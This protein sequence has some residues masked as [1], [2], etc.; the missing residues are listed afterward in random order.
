M[1]GKGK[2]GAKA[3]YLPPAQSR[4]S[5]GDGDGGPTITEKIKARKAAGGAEEW[6]AFKARVAK[7][8]Q[9]QLAVENHD[10]LMAA[11]HR[12][13]LD[14]ERDARLRREEQP[15]VEKKRKGRDESDSDDSSSS[16]SRKRHR[17]HKHKHKHRDKDKKKH[18]RRSHDKDK[19]KHR[20]KHKRRHSDSDSSDAEGGD[21]KNEPVPLSKFW[22]QS[23]SD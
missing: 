4:R 12:E 15:A 19:K 8:Q 20:S 23:D 9:E 16:A 6:D 11:Q 1:G 2:G 7:Q 3:A 13:M 18:R 21:A 10:V 17:K 22:Q 14:R 5:G